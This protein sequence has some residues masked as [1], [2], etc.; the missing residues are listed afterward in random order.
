MYKGKPIQGQR[1]DLR[2]SQQWCWRFSSS[3]ML[4]HTVLQKSGI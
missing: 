2:I 3:G 4:C 1:A